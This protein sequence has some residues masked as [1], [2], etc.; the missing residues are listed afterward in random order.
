[1]DEM[2]KLKQ[3]I[4][5][6]LNVDPN[7]ITPDS[8]FIEDLGADSLDVFQIV[9]ELEEEFQ[10]TIPQEKVEKIKTAGEAAA[11]IR[12]AVSHD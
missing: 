3:I 11:L 12:N 4:A 5:R 6:V 7:E 2:E 8:T 9:T 1:M 10:I